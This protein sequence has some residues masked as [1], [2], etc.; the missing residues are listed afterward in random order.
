MHGTD[1]TEKAGP[2]VIHPIFYFFPE[3][4]WGGPV[5]HS[6]LQRS[7]F[8]IPF[9]F[10]PSVDASQVRIC[11]RYDPFHEARVRNTIV[12]HSSIFTRVRLRLFAS[13]HRFSHDTMPFMNIFKK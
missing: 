12:G 13:I 7:A 9:Y 11:A 3:Y 6:M 2:L 4:I 5:Y 8:S 1:A 10:F